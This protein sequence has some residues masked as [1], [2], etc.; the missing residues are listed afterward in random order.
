MLVDYTETI[1]TVL[2]TQIELRRAIGLHICKNTPQN[3]YKQKRNKEIATIKT[4]HFRFWLCSEYKQWVAQYERTHLI[5]MLFLWMP[6]SNGEKR[7]SALVILENEINLVSNENTGDFGLWAYQ[8][9]LFRCVCRYTLSIVK[10]FCF[11]ACLSISCD[12]KHGFEAL[13]KTANE[14]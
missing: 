7:V 8:C 5:L 14:K 10:A 11:R 9:S 3:E 13:I 6:E 4:L 1:F 2:F 12:Y